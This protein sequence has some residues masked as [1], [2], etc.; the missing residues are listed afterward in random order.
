VF[1]VTCTSGGFYVNKSTRYSFDPTPAVNAHFSHEL[2][3][4]LLGAS[5]SLRSSWHGLCTYKPTT[6]TIKRPDSSSGALD[7]VSTLYSQGRE[8]QV[9][10][11]ET[12]KLNCYQ[13][14]LKFQ[15]YFVFDKSV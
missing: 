3:V 12:I 2:F 10:L 5:P 4:T 13:Q 9:H 15:L 14:L 7:V 6:T 1:H 11:Y 8:D